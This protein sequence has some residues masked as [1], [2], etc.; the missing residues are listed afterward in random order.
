MGKFAKGDHVKIP[1]ECSG[2]EEWA[3]VYVD[4]SD[5]QDGVGVRQTRSGTSLRRHCARAVHRRELLDRRGA[6]EVQ[7]VVGR[8]PPG[9]RALAATGFPCLS[10]KMS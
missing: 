9:A 10:A 7:L 2:E 5:E 6:Q 1:I 8:H 4:E 3:W